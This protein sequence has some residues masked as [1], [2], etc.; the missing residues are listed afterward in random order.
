MS[1]IDGIVASAGVTGFLPAF[2][3]PFVGPFASWSTRRRLTKLEA[4]YDALFHARIKQIESS[5]DESNDPVDLL[6]KMMRYAHKHR[7]EE[8]ET[9][10]MTRRL[11]MANLGFI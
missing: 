9:S 11:L 8:L 10:Q 3:R 7:P 2:L 5:P 1:A 6:Q 4:K